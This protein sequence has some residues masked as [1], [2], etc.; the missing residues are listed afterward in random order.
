M[1][2]TTVTISN[3][4]TEVA[5]YVKFSS[6]YAT[7]VTAEVLETLRDFCRDT[8]IWK[9]TLTD[10]SVVADTANYE[11]TVP[12]THGDSSEIKRFDSVKYKENGADDD[13]YRTLPAFTEDDKDRYEQGGWEYHTG[14]QPE[15]YFGK[16]TGSS[17]SVK[18]LC[19]YPIPTA[20]STD[21][22]R[23]KVACQP[24]DASTTV[25]Q[26][27]WDDYM[28]CI[29]IGTA[30]NLMNMPNKPWS[31]AE[32]SNYYRDQYQARR[33]EAYQDVKLGLTK[34]RK[35]QV[36]MPYTGGSRQSRMAW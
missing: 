16:L 4:N 3:W 33:D 1:A 12:T 23:I 10:V 28:R 11:L 32:M 22:L 36:R 19:L 17:N 29:A 34:E 35:Q 15:K 31:N 14:S 27:I 21:G 26:W 13:Q 18:T 24:S 6:S 2:I 30:G 7:L 5:K 9:E 25:P 8:G 20:A